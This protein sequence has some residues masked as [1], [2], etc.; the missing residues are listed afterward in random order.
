[1]I[2]IKILCGC[3]QKYAFDIES[4]AALLGLAIQ[5]PSCG[6]DGTAAANQALTAYA[7]P[8][9]ARTNGLQLR[10]HETASRGDIPF[11]PRIDV[12][13]R[14]GHASSPRRKWGLPLIGAALVLS[15]VLIGTLFFRNHPHRP[16]AI[17]S[18]TPTD[19]GLPQTVEQ[20]NAWYIEP[21]AGQNGATLYSHAFD[22]ME[23]RNAANVPLLGKAKLPPL[24][25]S[26]PPSMQ[27]ALATL[28]EANRETLQGFAQAATFVQSRYP[29]DLAEGYDVTLPHLAKWKDAASLL[30]L[31]AIFH[32]QAHDGKAAGRDV[33]N[34]LTLGRSLSLE[35][36]LISQFMRASTVRI[37]LATLEQTLNRT[38]LPPETLNELAKGFDQIAEPDTRGEPISR[39]LAGERINA[40]II[41][42]DP[43]KFLQK[44]TAPGSQV[45]TRAD[46]RDRWITALQKMGN[47]KE[48]QQFYEET[49]QQLMTARK[50]PFP[51]RI[52]SDGLMRKRAN[53]AAGR[54]LLLVGM[55]MLG[56]EGRAGREAGCLAHFR[57]GSTAIALEQFRAAHE[58]RYPASLSEFAADHPPSSMADPF[59]GEPLRYQR[60]GNG[61]LLYSLG[62]DRRDDLGDTSKDIVFTIVTPPKLAE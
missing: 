28:L 23:T 26:W 1:M 11:P 34:A 60:K 58:N 33:L 30:E 25:A 56:L 5:C 41:L 50:A 52:K 42:A 46:E 59:D 16:V 37:A 40:T 53:D 14:T 15:L 22:V 6:V 4:A 31:S 43:Q 62:Q 12:A 2:P 49:F 47:I 27:S 9:P 21:P 19:D 39:A 54:N 51:E 38:A 45:Y 32:A 48:Q 29:V 13:G 57:L 17:A 36:V 3:G 10:A 35:P 61:Y 24:G 44:L 8:Q 7:G 20:L 55:F 18:V